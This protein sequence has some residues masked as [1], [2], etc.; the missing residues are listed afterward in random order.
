M[1]S[2]WD[3]NNFVIGY[4]DLTGVED[5]AAS[6]NLRFYVANLRPGV[7][8]VSFV[9]DAPSR[10]VP[11]LA[12]YDLAGRRIQTLT[13]RRELTGRHGIIW[14]CRN[15]QGES[16]PSGMYFAR[17]TGA[18]FTRVLRVPVVR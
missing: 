15:A 17:L 5:G 16:V 12:V 6:S 2:Y 3:G 11:R 7:Q 9:V 18:G 13:E 14:D 1:S 8:S 10:I 4:P